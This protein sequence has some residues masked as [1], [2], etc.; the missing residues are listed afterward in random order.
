MTTKGRRFSIPSSNDSTNF[1]LNVHDTPETEMELKQYFGSDDDL[2]LNHTPARFNFSNLGRCKGVGALESYNFHRFHDRDHSNTPYHSTVCPTGRKT[3]VQQYKDTIHSPRLQPANE[4]ATR[5]ESTVAP[6]KMLQREA[7]AQRLRD[8]AHAMHTY[9][10]TQQAAHNLRIQSKVLEKEIIMDEL[11]KRLDVPLHLPSIHLANQTSKGN[12]SVSLE[13][14]RNN[15]KYGTSTFHYLSSSNGSSS[16][17]YKGKTNVSLTSSFKPHPPS[18]VNLPSKSLRALLSKRDTDK[19]QKQ[20]D[21]K[22][23][24]ISDM[25][26]K[27]VI[28]NNLE[29]KATSSENQTQ[30]D[31]TITPQTERLSLSCSLSGDFIDRKGSNI[32]VDSEIHSCP[33]SLVS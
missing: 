5:F 17:R 25:E 19:V 22:E 18:S 16:S 27:D 11:R 21:P 2:I 31:T 12:K 28:N 6:K 23:K 33:S 8:Y 24:E 14:R 13:T 20:V 32:D 15:A 7:C 26:K 10:T 1:I 9:N 4:R 29:A 30:E 3:L